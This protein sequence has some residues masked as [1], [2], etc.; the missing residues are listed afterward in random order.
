MAS[1][2]SPQH[3][4]EKGIP[5]WDGSPNEWEEYKE[6]VRWFATSISW[7]EANTVVPRLVRALRGSAWKM[8]QTLPEAVK[9]EIA[10]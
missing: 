6:K 1:K 2:F 7:K 9:T 10:S 5:S 3:Q 4:N 8:I